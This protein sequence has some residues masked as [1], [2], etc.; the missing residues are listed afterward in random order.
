MSY[1]SL[2]QSTMESQPVEVYHFYD[3]HG[4]HWRY[5]SNTE[6]QIIDFNDYPSKAI[7]REEIQMTDNHFKNELQIRLEKNNTFAISYVSGIIDDKIILDV[8]RFQSTASI[9]YWSG[10]VQRVTFDENEIPTLRAT[11]LSNEIISV[12]SR[13]RAQIM[14]DLPLYSTYCTVINSLFQ[15]AGTITAVD[16]VTLTSATFATK[17]NGWLT[18]GMIVIGFTRRLIQW[19]VSD[20][21]KM[22]R[23]IPNLTTGSGFIAYAGCDHTCDT[24]ETKFNNKINY[25]GCEFLPVTNPFVNRVVY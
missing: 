7:S 10:V 2:E 9:L 6:N 3:S 24:C 20:E 8:Y 5:T 21:I 4:N 25:G 14:C 16:G 22:G 13:R 1:D 23:A 11:P 17:A 18:G 19:H 15:I 12:G